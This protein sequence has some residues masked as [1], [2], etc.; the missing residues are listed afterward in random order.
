MSDDRLVPRQ[1]TRP[2]APAMIEWGND[3]PARPSRF[4]GG[5]LQDR[6]LV[7]VVVV[8]G[9]GVVAVLASLV[10]E[11]SVTTLANQEPT[12]EPSSVR[13]PAGLAEVGT[14]GVGYLV[15][16]LGIVSTLA[17]ALVGAAP[18]VR[19]DARVVGL[20]LSGGLLG[21]LTAMT[22][23]LGDERRGLPLSDDGFRVE[24][25]RGLVMA[26]V[27]TVLFGLALYLAGRTTN[28]SDEAAPRRHRPMRAVEPSAE[29]AGEEPAGPAD[30]TVT[31]ATPFVRPD[32]LT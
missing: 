26:F 14:F 18:T 22:A 4:V 2:D 1:D 23:S 8:A 19:H 3:A 5:L 25:G 29:P 20:V 15:G 6:R 9:L 7:V 10:G 17:L 30:L 16:L 11:W 32:Q 21:M 27:G 12:G 31:P 24:P 13:V 28:S